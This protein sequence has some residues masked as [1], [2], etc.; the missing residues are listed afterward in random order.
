MRPAHYADLDAAL[1]EAF[2]LL[3]GAVSDRRSPFHTPTLATIGL[4]GRPRLRTVVLRHAEADAGGLAMR[5][6]TDRRSAKFAELQR[7]PRAALHGYDAARKIQLR[8]EG[9]ISLHTDDAVADAAWAA[10]R[11]DSLACYG[12]EPG[13]GV[14][15]PAPDG[16]AMPERGGETGRDNFAAAAFHAEQLEWLYLAHEGHRRAAFDLS[17]HAPA[18]RCWLTP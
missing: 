16:Y 6:H 18:R 9:R 15:L 13:P 4:D 2:A 5:F 17:P 3:R 1:A 8:L 14:R 11:P 12:V 10:S 7:D